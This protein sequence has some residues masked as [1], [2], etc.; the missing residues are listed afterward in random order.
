MARPC[1]NRPM[2]AAVIARRAVLLAAVLIAVLL[3]MAAGLLVAVDKGYGRSLLIHYV[4]RRIGHPIEV[5]G[6]LQ[7]RLFA[8]HPQMTAEDVIID[9][10]HWMPAGV[11]AEV[12]RVTVIFV[13][14]GSGEP[15]GIAQFALQAA[16]VHLVRDAAG[17]ANWPLSDPDKARPPPSKWII[18]S[19]SI[20]NAHVQLADAYRDRHFVGTVSAHTG[21]GIEAAPPLR[22]EGTGQLNGRAVSFTLNADPLTTARH[23]RPY[24]FSF[25][26]HSSGSHLEAQGALPQP[27]DFSVIEASFQATGPDL[28]DL[29]FLTGAKLLDTGPYHLASKVL[30][31]GKFSEYRDLVAASGRSDV[32]GT[33]SNDYSGA[34]PRWNLALNSQALYLSDFGIRAAG[35]TTEPPSPLLLP[36][37]ELS[38]KLLRADD[39]TVNFHAHSVEAGRLPLQEVSLRATIDNG[40]LTVAPLLAQVLG[41]SLEAHGTLDAKRRVPAA[42]VD[43]KVTDLQLAQ[44]PYKD[45][46]APPIAG[47]LQAQVKVTGTGASLHQIAASA[48]GTVAMQIPHGAIRES[49][50]ESAGGVDLHGARLLLTHDKRDVP[51]HCAAATFTAANG[52]LSAQ[53]LVADTDPELVSGEGQI[54]LDTE[55][56]DLVLHGH[57]RRTRLLRLRAPVLVRGTLAH[58]SVSLQKAGPLPCLSIG[59]EPGMSTAPNCLPRQELLP[60]QWLPVEIW[61]ADHAARESGDPPRLRQ[62]VRGATH[63]STVS[64]FLAVLAFWCGMLAAA[65]AYPGGYDWRYQT[66]SVLLYADQNPHGY[67]WAWAALWLCGL[68]GFV[69]TS[70]P[71]RNPASTTGGPPAAGF[72]VLQL[73]FLCM[74]CAVLPD[75]LL[76]WSKGH[77]FFA[78]LAFL[79]ISIGVTRLL[80]VTA[81]FRASYANAM[82]PIQVRIKRAVAWLPVVPLL[83]AG[84]TQAYLALERPDLPW[85]TRQWRTRGISPWLSFG[86][87]EWLSCAAFSVC[88]LMLWNHRRVDATQR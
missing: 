21:V 77:E 16:T 41:G 78:I 8:R 20:S 59:A 3:I 35:R 54:H 27:F 83:L 67:F 64:G 84:S 86:L 12:G 50:A 55:D 66:I 13:R 19:L 39:A 63:I 52:T 60:R 5:K 14:P 81:D 68:A 26:E 43:L 4:A 48:N 46:G 2:Q 70:A 37:A 15:S 38:T 7:V 17:H 9:N 62:S 42:H 6:T 32:H 88:L 65:L 10:P 58:P 74:C 29:Y 40:V 79:G 28:K 87:W 24:H 57:A 31:R 76:P 45:P 1:V 69:W 85:V 72:R 61:N 71:G 75:R 23:D 22:I 47:P 82:T 49:M 11:M 18:R 51:I 36:S 25:A 53:T 80:W 73:G 33:V 44:F 30:F 56:L 34:R